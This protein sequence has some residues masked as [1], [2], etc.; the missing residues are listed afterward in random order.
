MKPNQQVRQLTS[1]D[2]FLIYDLV[3]QTPTYF[4]Q[5]ADPA[6]I[7]N[8]IGGLLEDRAQEFWGLYDESKGRLLS[9]MGQRM[10]ARSP[11]W[12]ENYVYLDKQTTGQYNLFT[13]GFLDVLAVA[14]LYAEAQHRHSFLTAFVRQE[15]PTRI[16]VTSRAIQRHLP[17]GHPLLGYTPSTWYAGQGEF[18]DVQY[19]LGQP[20]P[21]KPECVILQWTRPLV[22]QHIPTPT[23]P[24]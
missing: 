14:I 3:K 9:M 8:I 19:M 17:G 1:A 24:A 12:I 11:T 4:G 18:A 2:V 5:P 6:Q 15:M 7:V 23:N 21:T 13:T 20:S 16:R 10:A 22:V